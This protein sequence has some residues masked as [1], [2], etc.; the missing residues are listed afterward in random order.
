MRRRTRALFA[1]AGVIAVGLVATGVFSGQAAS[2]HTAHTLVA[3]EK[4]TKTAQQDFGD[5]GTSIGDRYVFT[6]E[7]RDPRGAMLGTGFGDC[8]LIG[9]TTDADGQYNCVQTYHLAGGDFVTSGFFDFAQK[10]NKWAI[11]GGT[12]RYRA[13]T[14]QA[15]FTTLSGD[16]F[17]DT[18]RIKY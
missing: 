15:D 1:T 18:F 12:G 11:I 16:T 7:I 13:A 10:V 5:K 8:V 9:G 3:R 4:F 14:G 17:A 2:A 6:S